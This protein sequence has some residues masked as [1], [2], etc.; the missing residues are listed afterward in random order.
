M[1][2]QLGEGVPEFRY[3]EVLAC[4]SAVS[5]VSILLPIWVWLPKDFGRQLGLIAFLPFYLPYAFIPLRLYG[6]RLRSGLTLA[7]TMGCALVVP[8]VYLVRYAITW[9]RRWLVLGNLIVALLMQLVLIVVGVKAYIRLPRLPRTG[10]RVWAGPAYG[11]TLFTLFLCFHSPVPRYISDNEY[12]AMSSLEASAR[13]ARFDAEQHGMLFPEALGN[14]D[15]NHSGACT[16]E[17]NPP[18]DGYVIDYRGTQPSST[19]QGC[20]RYK[21]FIITARPVTFGKTGIRS[22]LIDSSGLGIH[23]TSENRPARTTDPKDYVRHMPQ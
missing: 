2:P 1:T 7:I 16:V 19:F 6:Q 21:G 14:F 5:F 9:D 4:A 18:R 23:F 10:L 20:T 3:R 12:A 11:F 17:M 15:P 22:F 8:G 13:N